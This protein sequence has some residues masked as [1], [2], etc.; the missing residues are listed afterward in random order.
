[1]CAPC[2][3]P[4]WPTRAL[5]GKVP[6]GGRTWM[7]F[8]VADEGQGAATRINVSDGWNFSSFVGVRS[9]VGCVQGADMTEECV[10]V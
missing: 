4:S 5:R 2:L 7:L 10:Q 8:R 1:M 6:G 9:H 3:D